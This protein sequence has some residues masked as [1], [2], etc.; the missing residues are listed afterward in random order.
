TLAEALAETTCFDIFVHELDAE[1][2]DTHREHSLEIA[3]TVRIWGAEGQDVVFS[4]TTPNV[5]LF[6]VTGG[7]RLTLGGFTI[8]S[9]GGMGTDH[10]GAIRVEDGRLRLSAMV[11]ES[12]AAQNGG[13]IYAD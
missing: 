13:V 12:N 8:S 3:R 9:Y 11:F 6:R 7:A 1:G 10:G 5:R 4:G 2:E